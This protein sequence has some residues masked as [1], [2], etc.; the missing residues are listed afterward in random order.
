LPAKGLGL[1]EVA[2]D[3]FIG[4]TISPFF[5]PLFAAGAELAM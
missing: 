4:D 3:Q 1:I 5:K 2:G